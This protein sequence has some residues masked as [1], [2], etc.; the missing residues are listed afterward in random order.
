MVC[1]GV[2][3][4]QKNTLDIRGSMTVNGNIKQT[5]N[6]VITIS[7]TGNLCVTGNME[8]HLTGTKLV[9]NG[10]TLTVGGNVTKC[11]TFTVNAPAVVTI[12]GTSNVTPTV[13]E[14]ATVTIN[15]KTIS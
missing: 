10:G 11:K 15:G 4:G 5:N 1:G 14:G 2:N 6:S 8:L 12:T 3:N 7:E 9:V 13:P